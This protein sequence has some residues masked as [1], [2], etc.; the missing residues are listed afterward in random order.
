MAKQ[1]PDDFADFYV[2]SCAVFLQVQR[3]LLAEI[4]IELYHLPQLC[5]LVLRKR[6]RPLKLLIVCTLLRCGRGRQDTAEPQLVVVKRLVRVTTLNCRWLV[7]G[8]WWRI[9]SRLL[10]LPQVFA[11][12]ARLGMGELMI[13]SPVCQVWL[14]FFAFRVMKRIGMFA[15]LRHH[16]ATIA[17]DDRFAADGGAGV[18]PLIAEGLRH[19]KLDILV[20]L[21]RVVSL[22][23][24]ARV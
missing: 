24:E 15:L 13:L 1:I 19:F 9:H 14:D 5:I 12:W 2:E 16:H 8:G 22:S 4:L 17:E 18:A 6:F 21:H 20:F 11:G 10:S 23:D 7:Q 3:L